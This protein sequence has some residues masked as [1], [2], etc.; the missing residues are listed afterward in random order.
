MIKLKVSGKT[1]RVVTF[2]LGFESG[3]GDRKGF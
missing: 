3:K 2:G 1:K